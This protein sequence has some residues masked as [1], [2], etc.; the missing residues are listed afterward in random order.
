M[1]TSPDPGRR[2]LRRVATTVLAALA[3][4]TVLAAAGPGVELLF[5]DVGVPA[6]AAEDAAEH[7]ADAA[8]AYLRDRRPELYR[9]WGI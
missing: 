3:L 6:D 8:V 1:T 7:G 2:L 4:T 5:A 9:A